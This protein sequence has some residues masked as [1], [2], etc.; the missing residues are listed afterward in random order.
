MRWDRI[1]VSLTVHLFL[2][3][4]M[5]LGDALGL[6]NLGGSR[7]PPKFPWFFLVFFCVFGQSFVDRGAK[8]SFGRSWVRPW[9]SP[10]HRNVP[11]KSIPVSNVHWL[12]MGWRSVMGFNSMD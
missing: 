5:N 12:L 3:D 9:C 2:V 10:P 8:W 6:E 4:G 11:I 1:G 7:K